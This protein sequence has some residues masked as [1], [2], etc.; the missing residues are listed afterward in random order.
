MSS[1]FALPAHTTSSVCLPPQHLP[2][3]LLEDLLPGPVTLLLARRHD[4]PL[5]PEL[6]PGVAAI[7]IRIPDAPFIRAVARQHRTALALTSANI[8]GGMSSIDVAEFQVRRGVEAGGGGQAGMSTI[9][10]AHPVCAAS[11]CLVCPH[12]PHL[13]VPQDLWPACSLVFDG[14]RLD[15]GRSGS[16]VVDLTRPGTFSIGRRGPGFARTMQL[17]QEK[18]GLRHDLE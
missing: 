1:A 16:T 6:N 3:G 14:G 2:R 9:T 15:A 7:G 17:L 18:Y 11:S 8:S 12:P 5:A 4:A 13:P 10:A